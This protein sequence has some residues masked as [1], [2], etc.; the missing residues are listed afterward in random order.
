MAAMI[1]AAAHLHAEEGDP[2]VR[3]VSNADAPV[4][5]VSRLPKRR[6]NDVPSRRS[7]LLKVLA[8]AFALLM[9][10]SGMAFAGILPAPLQGAVDQWVG[11]DDDQG[12][13]PVIDRGPHGARDAR[14]SSVPAR[15]AVPPG[16]GPGRGVRAVAVLDASRLDPD[17]RPFSEAAVRWTR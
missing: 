13:A 10:F 3:P 2:A 16:Y 8:P 4:P 11:D 12:N 5:Q 1:E 9:L 7:I 14:R 17:P 15:T 6:G